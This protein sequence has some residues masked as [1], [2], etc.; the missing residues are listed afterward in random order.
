MAVKYFIKYNNVFH[1]KAL[2]NMPKLGFWYK[3]K[4][5]SGNPGANAYFFGLIAIVCNHF[6]AQTKKT[7]G[8]RK[9][10]KNS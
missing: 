2:K 9:P 10:I 7:D 5:P 6:A 1:S 3:N 8:S 4:Q